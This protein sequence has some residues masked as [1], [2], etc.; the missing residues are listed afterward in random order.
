MKR[1]STELPSSPLIRPHLPLIPLNLLLP[2]RSTGSAHIHL[3]LSLIL[4]ILIWH[5]NSPIFF[6]RLVCAFIAPSRNPFTARFVIDE[7]L[8][9]FLFG[10]GGSRFAAVFTDSFLAG[11]E[12]P[13]CGFF[14]FGSISSSD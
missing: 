13:F 4:P 9:S 2:L 1:L 14:G 3:P 10:E 12:L 5:L 8:A 11:K 7:F 6:T